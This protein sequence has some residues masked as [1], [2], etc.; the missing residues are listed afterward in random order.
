MFFIYKITNSINKKTYVGA[1]S[2]SVIKRFA[3][4]KSEQTDLSKDIKKYGDDNF[5]IETLVKTKNK[6][7]AQELE[8]QYIVKFD[9]IE[10]GYNKVLR[11]NLR[12]T[13]PSELKRHCV[14]L[15]DEAIQQAKEISEHYSGTKNV[16][17]GVRLALNIVK[18]LDEEVKKKVANGE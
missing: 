14:V 12:I 16:S 17:L 1:T 11:S 10:N 4:H 5:K 7:E 2:Q 6:K 18:D 13:K 9:C 15:D 8:K 3:G